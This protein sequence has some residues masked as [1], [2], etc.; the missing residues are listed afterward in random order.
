LVSPD[1]FLE[2]AEDTGLMIAISDWILGEVC[3]QLHIW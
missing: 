3:R 2:V 1:D